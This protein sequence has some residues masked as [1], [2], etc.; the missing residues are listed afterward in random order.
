MCLVG[1]YVHTPSQPT[2]GGRAG[3]ATTK[4]RLEGTPAASFL[5]MPI[6]GE[7]SVLEELPIWT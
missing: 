5:Q 7:K 2:L 4:L 6:L 1:R 3:G